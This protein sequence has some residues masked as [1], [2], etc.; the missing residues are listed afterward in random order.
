M[1]NLNELFPETEYSLDV[2]IT[3]VPWVIE[4][5]WQKGKINVVFGAEKSGKSRLVNWLLVH[6]MLGLS[7]QG[8]QTRS[9]PKRVL[10]MAAEETKAEVNSRMLG[11]TAKLNEGVLETFPVT[12]IDAAGMRLDLP[13]YRA[14]LEVK[15]IEGKF[16]MLVIDPLRRIHGGNEND[17]S[18]MSRIFNDF[19]RWT[20]RYGITMVLLHHTGKPKEGDDMDRTAN[21]GRGASDLATVLDTAVLVERVEKLKL[22]IRRQGR[23]A[24]LPMLY[25]TDGTEEGNP[26]FKRIG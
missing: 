19:R 24:P 22:R 16:D 4:G 8:L 3:E 21:W 26:V 23:Y 6:L 18:E 7:M 11:Y 12:Y 10:Y 17:N 14:W 13:E 15:L 20:N 9:P 5:L 1:L 2:E 25:L